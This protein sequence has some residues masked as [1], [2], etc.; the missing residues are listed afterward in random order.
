MQDRFPEVESDG[1][2]GCE[3]YILVNKSTCSHGRNVSLSAI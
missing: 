1:S 3:F 2:K